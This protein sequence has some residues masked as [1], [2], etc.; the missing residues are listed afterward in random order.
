[1]RKIKKAD[2]TVVDVDKDYELQDDEEEVTEPEGGDDDEVVSE[3]KSIL[4]NR[5]KIAVEDLKSEVKKEMEEK[6][7]EYVERQKEIKD[8]KAGLYHE[9]IASSRKAKSEK[10]KA[11]LSLALGKD[12]SDEPL[13]TTADDEGGYLTDEELDAEI[14]HL[15][16]EYGVVRREFFTTPMEKTTWKGNHLVSDVAS[17]WIDEGDKYSTSKITIGQRTL[18]LKKLGVIV[19][20]TNELLNDSEVDLTRF[21]T[22]RVAEEFAY[23]ED[24]AGLVG[25][26]SSTYGGF[27]GILNDGNAKTHTIEGHDDSEDGTSFAHFSPDDVLSARDKIEGDNLNIKVYV[28]RSLR[29]NLRTRKDDNGNYILESPAGGAQLNG[30]WGIDIVE[31]R[32]LPSISDDAEG[33]AFAIV[34]DLNKACIM[35][36]KGGFTIE[37]FNT[38]TI[39]DQAGTGDINLL[40]TDRKAVRFKERVGFLNMLPEAVCVIKTAT[41]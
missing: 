12:V 24:L 35:G 39:Q 1:M 23:R 34:G 22:E 16:K 37:E 41:S 27:T 28:H 14:R 25:D 17:S 4:N 20:M 6:M 13:R 18:E 11:H 21:V 19:A 31:S 38:G 9:D 40:T 33:T 2:G 29:D 26:G 8:K 3:I 15:T 30:V 7:K 5:V 32:V 10:V 36:Y